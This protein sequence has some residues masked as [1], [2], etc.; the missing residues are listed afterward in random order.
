M[1]T[2]KPTV[3]G[4]LVCLSVLAAQTWASSIPGKR[5]L[6]Q[7]IAHAELIFE[8][9]VRKVWTEPHEEDGFPLTL[10]LVE[11]QRF[12]KGSADSKKLVIFLPGGKY[13]DGSVLV[14]P[15]TPRLLEGDTVLV[16]AVAKPHSPSRVRLV[17]F[18][19]AL[20]RKMRSPEGRLVPENGQGRVLASLPLNEPPTFV[21]RALQPI[22]SPD[23]LPEEAPKRVE[24]PGPHAMTWEAVTKAVKNAV[25]KSGSRGA[26]ARQLRGYVATEP[27]RTGG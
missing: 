21:R 15:G 6:S 16:H 22:E 27:G 19:N 3:L 5:N 24:R 12:F 1:R 11:I 25:A 23:V 18:G 2:L 7:I 17:D 10:A 9:S 4:T 20:L 26:M 13:P 14:V 8:G